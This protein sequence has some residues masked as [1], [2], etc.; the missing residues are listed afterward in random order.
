MDPYFR[1]LLV[2]GF[3]PIAVLFLGVA[4]F[5]FA[6]VIGQISKGG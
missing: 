2:I 4:L 6:W 5:F 3:I 1:I